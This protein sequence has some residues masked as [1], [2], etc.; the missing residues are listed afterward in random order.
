MDENATR[1][2][3]VTHY[4]VK[5]EDD[6]STEDVHHSYLQESA[7]IPPIDISEFIRILQHVQ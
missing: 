5:V 4:Y 7:N 1:P 3:H 2:E 6:S